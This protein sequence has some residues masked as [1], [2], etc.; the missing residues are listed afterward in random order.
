[1][2]GWHD[3][4]ADL[5]QA[6]KLQ[7]LGIVQEQ[8]ADRARLFMQWRQMGWPILVDAFDLLEVSVVPLTYAIDEHGIV[9]FARLRLDD[10]D[11]LEERFVDRT[12]PAPAA[13]APDTPTADPAALRTLAR[14]SLGDEA[15]IGDSIEAFR[16]ATTTRPEDGWAHF[17]LAVAYR[18]RYDAASRR[19]GDFQAAVDH[20][21][22]ALELDPNNYIWRRRIQQYGPRLA[23]PYPFYDWIETAR[24]EIRARGE[25]PAALAS[26]PTG[27]E[28]AEPS[29]TLTTAADANEPDPEGRVIRDGIDGHGEALPRPLIRAEVT[30]VPR[31][32]DAGSATRAHLVLTPD[33]GLRAH[34]NNESEPLTVWVAPPSGWALDQRRISA[35]NAEQATSTEVRRLEVELR[36][37][38]DAPAGAVEIPAYAIYYVCEDVDGTCL[39][40]RQDLAIQ[41]EVAAE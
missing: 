36:A 32:V 4:T 14:A 17:R 25:T 11:T 33:A 34:W 41:L 5:Q 22:R 2:P 30:A 16:A 23:K 37:P 19:P 7:M 39:I 15:A 28:I 26:E 6:G 9:R 21:Q 29:R 27:S 24:A 38:E 12:W 1:M 13:S 3:A 31:R 18:L 40:R 20:W 10:A 8:N 35:P